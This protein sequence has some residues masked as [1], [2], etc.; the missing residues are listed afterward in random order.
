[1]MKLSSIEKRASPIKSNGLP[2]E[3][4]HIDSSAEERIVH[5]VGNSSRDLVTTELS[6]TPKERSI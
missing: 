4:S 2:L 1:M 3:K 6:E 5:D